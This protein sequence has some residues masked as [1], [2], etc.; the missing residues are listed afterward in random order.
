M[1]YLN[2]TGISAIIGD[3]YFSGTTVLPRNFPASAADDPLVLQQVLYNMIPKPYCPNELLDLGSA[4]TVLGNLSNSNYPIMFSK[5]PSSGNLTLTQPPTVGEQN[6]GTSEPATI[7]V[8]S[9]RVVCNKVILL[10]DKLLPLPKQ[11]NASTTTLAS[12]MLAALETSPPRRITCNLQTYADLLETPGV[13][14]GLEVAERINSGEEATSS[15]TESTVNGS[16]SDSAVTDNQGEGSSS[17]SNVG[18]IAGSVVAGVAVLAVLG[19]FVW[20]RKQLKLK[21]GNFRKGALNASPGS[22]TPKSKCSPQ[23]AV[24][25]F[26][27]QGDSAEDSL[28][29]VVLQMPL[30][31][32]V[33]NTARVEFSNPADQNVVVESLGKRLKDTPSL[34]PLRLTAGDVT[35]DVDRFGKEVVLGR[36]SFG[37]VFRGTLRGVQP[38]AGKVCTFPGEEAEKKFIR[39]AEILQHVSRDKNIV[40]LYGI[41]TVEDKLILVMELMEGGDLRFA[42][43]NDSDGLLHWSCCGKDIS[44]DIARGITALHACNVIHRD[45]K[46]KNVLLSSFGGSGSIVAKLGDVGVSTWLPTNGFLSAG[47]GVV[48]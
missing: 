19:V 28:H 11:A 30:D 32:W 20:K 22:S 26:E 6:D 18:V 36:G 14:P 4:N 21:A 2:E 27:S 37:S 42:L 17:S 12:N 7:V 43:D 10:V 23:S 38:V 5:D 45:I 9:D 48:G 16:P 29:Q 25:N 1:S 40:Q 41:A 44:L 3:L 46:S 15:S 24:G 13:R 47:H 39:E 33:A 31:S 35:V 8:S 34:L